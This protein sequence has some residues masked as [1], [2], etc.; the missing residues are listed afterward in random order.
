[1]WYY[2]PTTDYFIAML[3][4]CL[5][6][7]PERKGDILLGRFCRSWS[8]QVH[9]RALHLHT[10]SCLRQDWVGGLW[11]CC[12]D[13]HGIASIGDPILWGCP[14]GS[15]QPLEAHC[16]KCTHPPQPPI[17]IDLGRSGN[18]CK[19]EHRQSWRLEALYHVQSYWVWRSWHGRLFA[20]KNLAD[21]MDKPK[22]SLC[23]FLHSSIRLKAPRAWQIPKS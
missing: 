9:E 1:M 4:P 8:L 18:A 11:G 19:N 10:D 5:A 17:A 14:G 15:I 2:L 21:V 6:F 23:L 20:I 22:S 16:H 12:T 7:P 3:P 13:N